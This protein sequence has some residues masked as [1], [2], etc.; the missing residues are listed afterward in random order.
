MYCARPHTEIGKQ[1]AWFTTDLLALLG[2]SDA[3]IREA[4]RVVLK[5]IRDVA[6]AEQ[7]SGEDPNAQDLVNDDGVAVALG[8]ETDGIGK[9]YCGRMLGETVMPDTSGRCGPN[10]G[11]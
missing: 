4:T 11:P 3:E 10:N 5:K 7:A 6:E 9:Y 1:A 2:D 8:T